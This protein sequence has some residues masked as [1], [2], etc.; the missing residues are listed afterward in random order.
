[1]NLPPFSSI[2]EVVACISKGVHVFASQ[3]FSHK[4]SLI[5]LLQVASLVSPVVF[6]VDDIE[7]GSPFV[8]IAN[9]VLLPHKVDLVSLPLPFILH[10]LPPLEIPLVL[11]N[12][13]RIYQLLLIPVAHV[14]L[15]FL[16][17]CEV[18]HIAIFGRLEVTAL[19]VGVVHQ[20]VVHILVIVADSI[21]EPLLVAQRKI[22]IILFEH[23]LTKLLFKLTVVV[24]LHLL[25]IPLRLE[26]HVVIWLNKCSRLA[27]GIFT[28]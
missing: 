25:I 1:M 17:S 23:L 5:S 3:L 22:G 2:K 9:L 19:G 4:C 18:S 13:S 11:L 21:S 20:Y 12:S 7:G 15:S 6:Q 14:S 28:G 10:V 24:R 26:L 8:G 16:D 27:S